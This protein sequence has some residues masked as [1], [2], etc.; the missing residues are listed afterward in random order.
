MIE[1]TGY[2]S[3]EAEKHFW[4]KN[5][6]FGIKIF[7]AAVIIVFPMVLYLTFQLQHYI[8]IG[9]Y[10]IALIV[11]VPLMLIN[12]QSKKDKKS[13]TPNRIFTD[14]ESITCV[15]EKFTETRYIEDAKLVYDYGDFYEFVFPFGKVSHNFICQK[16][17]LTSGTLEAFEKL[18]EHKMI[19]AR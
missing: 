15:T 5:K 4:K 1:F 11:T 17:L 16:S 6:A 14:G 9:I 7:L 3:G 2:L 8:A 12:P 10:G 13:L 18:F 19:I